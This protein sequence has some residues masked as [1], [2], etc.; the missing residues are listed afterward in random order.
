LA[1]LREIALDDFRLLIEQIVRTIQIS[2]LHEENKV[3]CEELVDC[4][5][6]MWRSSS[7]MLSAADWSKDCLAALR[8]VVDTPR[9]S[10]P[11]LS[12]KAKFGLMDLHDLAAAA[13]K[14]AAAPKPASKSGNSSSKQS[15]KK[16]SA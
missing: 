15:K 12:N 11:G 13:A 16:S 6:T 1:K 4:L 9:A 2:Y 10:S 3:L 14:P 8:A 7:G 5:L